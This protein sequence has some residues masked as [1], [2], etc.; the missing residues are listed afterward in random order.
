MIISGLDRGEQVLTPDSLI[1]EFGSERV[2]IEDTTTGAVQKDFLERFLATFN[3]PGRQYPPLKVKV[4]RVSFRSSSYAEPLYQDWPPSAEFRRKFP[5]L[6]RYFEKRLPG[7]D[8]SSSE[9]H[10]N[11]V[12]SMPEKSNPPD[13]GMV[14]HI[15][16]MV[17]CELIRT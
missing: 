2:R 15:S 4:A 1:R 8:I 11:L 13:A 6:F 14:L 3:D 17:I 12:S 10:L 7:S 5:A 16:F 9:G